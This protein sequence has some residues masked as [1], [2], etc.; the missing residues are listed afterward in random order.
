MLEKIE[1]LRQKKGKIEINPDYTPQGRARMLTQLQQEAAL[2][3]GQAAAVLARE[4]QQVRKNYAD[5]NSRIA[6][7]EDAAAAGWDYNRL[8]YAKAAVE[9]AV[10]K[11]GDLG[12]I[13]QV[14]QAVLASGDTHSRR[15]WAENLP[16]LVAEKWPG[17]F[18]KLNRIR[19]KTE[20]DLDSLTITP[21]LAD[22]RGERLAA[23]KKA[24]ALV[25]DTK[26]LALWADPDVGVLGRENEFSKLL[27]GVKVSKKLDGLNIVSTLTIE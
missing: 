8:L 23:T 3:R 26:A 27:T 4:W 12:E 22:L 5:L 14:Y 2:F 6:K 7:E 10:K 24:L 16:Q 25:D 11:A 9:K 17:D 18:E 15:A 1:E 21:R 19:P 13:E 20:R